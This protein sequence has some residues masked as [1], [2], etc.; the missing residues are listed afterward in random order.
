MIPTEV[1]WGSCR[2]VITTGSTRADVLSTKP[3]PRRHPPPEER[4]VP[5]HCK[6]MA[7]AWLCRQRPS[8]AYHRIIAGLLQIGAVAGQMVGVSIARPYP[9][10]FASEVRWT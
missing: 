4:A 8:G 3:L 6:P 9:P 5:L 1:F 2:R 10:N 7:F